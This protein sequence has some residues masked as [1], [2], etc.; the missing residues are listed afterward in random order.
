MINGNIV[1]SCK[2]SRS[3]NKMCVCERE[4][5]EA[6]VNAIIRNKRRNREAA[7]KIMVMHTGPCYRR[8]VTFFRALIID[9]KICIISWH[10]PHLDQRMRVHAQFTAEISFY[11][12]HH[13]F[14]SAEEFWGGIK[15]VLPSIRTKN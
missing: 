4:R 2:M 1:H 12:C 9:H 6:A 5:G 7:F 13:P 14:L 3:D 11:S 8:N 15:I 10:R